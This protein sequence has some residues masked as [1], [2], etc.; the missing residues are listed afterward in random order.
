MANEETSIQENPQQFSKTGK[1]L[2]YL[3]QESSLLLGVGVST[4]D[5]LQL[6]TKGFLS[7]QLAA[8]GLSSLEEDF[9]FPTHSAPKYW[10]LRLSPR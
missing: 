1:S 6:R 4:T 2:W 8:G 10:L 7:T 5:L 9:T 3:N